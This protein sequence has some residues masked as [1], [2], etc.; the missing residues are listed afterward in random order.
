MTLDE[1]VALLIIEG[2]FREAL[3]LDRRQ[4]RIG[5]RVVS[6]GELRRLLKDRLYTSKEGIARA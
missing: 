2:K 5:V 6:D 1:K 4:Y 3:R